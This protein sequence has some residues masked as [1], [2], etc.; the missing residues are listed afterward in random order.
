MKS[1]PSPSTGFAQYALRYALASSSTLAVVVLSLGV[2]PYYS[3]YLIFG[4]AAGLGLLSLKAPKL[5][6]LMGILL[7]IPASLYQN[8]ALAMILLPE[9]TIILVLASRSYLAGL[10]SLFAFGSSFTFLAPLAPVAIVLAGLVLGTRTGAAVGILTALLVTVV[11]LS[12]GVHNLGVLLLPS[13]PAE[14]RL[15]NPIYPAG[16]NLFSLMQQAQ[17]HYRVAADSGPLIS[18]LPFLLIQISLWG[19]AAYVSGKSIRNISWL[20]SRLVPFASNLLGLLAILIASEFLSNAFEF[21]PS[22]LAS[23]GVMFVGGAIASGVWLAVPSSMKS[24]A[25]PGPDISEQSQELLSR[26]KHDLEVERGKILELTSRLEENRKHNEALK[27]QLF[28]VQTENRRLKDLVRYLPREALEPNKNSPTVSTGVPDLDDVLNGGFPKNSAVCITSVPRDELDYFIRSYLVAGSVLGTSFY[29]AS[30]GSLVGDLISGTGGRVFGFVTKPS[31]SEQQGVTFVG[32]VDN[33]TGLNI[34]FSKIL[35][36]PPEGP[37]RICVDILSDLLLHSGSL[38]ARDWLR[39][40]IHRLKK[41]DFTILAVLHSGM[42]SSED[43]MR[44]LEIFDGQV[45]IYDQEVAGMK[46]PYMRVSR[47]ELHS[48]KHEEIP[49]YL[50]IRSVY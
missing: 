10:F 20:D 32:D 49:V 40:F 19:A 2:I 50:P 35:S 36:E 29:L 43:V 24:I 12:F 39:D 4:I 26:H 42:H 44:I 48:Y 7:L 45:E 18:A 11:G 34:N 33:L 30:D 47:M 21:Q 9:I 37:K 28:K 13:P 22:L 8:P 31:A 14:N 38:T 6:V 5:A 16:D 25:L 17:L 27:N 23:Y 41:L 3:T 15:L 1:T 46:R